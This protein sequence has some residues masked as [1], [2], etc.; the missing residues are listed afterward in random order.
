[1]IAL[2]DYGLGNIH[3]FAN[4]YKSLNIPVVVADNA[5]KLDGADHI[6]LP[7]VGAFDWAMAKLNHSGMRSLLDEMVLVRKIPVLG[8]CVGMQMMAHRSD[9]GKMSGLGWIGGD[10]KKFDE[11]TFVQQTHLPHMGWNNVLPQKTV[12]LFADMADKPLFYFLHSY[13]FSPARTEDSLALT[14]YNGMFASAVGCDNVFGMQ[15]HPEKSHR[16]GIQLLKN[17]AGL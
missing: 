17:F 15:F 16:A 5:E 9:E 4:I 13:Y 10:V 12:G 14:N 1:M 2:V 6:I 11:A 8:V 3:A 7:G